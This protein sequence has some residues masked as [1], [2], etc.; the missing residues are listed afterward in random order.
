MGKIS[1]LPNQLTP[2]KERKECGEE[3]WLR[4]TFMVDTN[5]AAGKVLW[6][7]FTDQDFLY[8]GKS[9]EQVDPITIIVI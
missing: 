2:L 1:R 9:K 6:T 3:G 8:H 4:P 7:R 5:K